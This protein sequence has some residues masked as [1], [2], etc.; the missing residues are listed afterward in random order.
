MLVCPSC[1][2]E[3]PERA[4]FCLAC[5]QS[6]AADARPT[7]ERKVVSVLFVDLVGFTDRSDR[8]DPEDVRATLRPY[9]ERVKA[10]IEAFG[11]TVEKFIG[12]AVMAV[13]GAPTAYEDD[14]ERAVR[15][16]LRI[17]ETMQ[18]LRGEGLD[19]AVR[20][21]VTTGEAVV[22]L[23][24]RPER[25][26]GIVAGDVVNTAARLQGA[27]PIG[28][29]IVD[30]ATMRSAERAIGFEPLESVAAKGK[31]D[32]IPVWR[33][34]TARS[35]F[36]VDTELRAE[37]L[38]VG[39]DSE[40]ALLSE[41]FARA[42]REPSTQLVT[43]VAEPGVGKSR[44]VW[45]FREEID[46]RPDLVR[47]RQGRCLPY[48]DGITFWALG[49][50]VKAEAGVLETDSPAEALV[51]LS[52]VVGVLEDE[53]DR[54]W[55][56]ERLAPLVGA[57]D[58]V[59][60][61]GR[62]EAFSAWQ[63]YLEALAVQ[64]P[65]VLVIEDL[66]WADAALLDFVE[67][68]LDWT[69]DVPLMVLATARPEL[70]DTRP[71]WSGGRR[72]SA[73]LGLSPLSDEDTARL[74]SSLLERSVLPAETQA[75]LLERAGGNPLYAEQYVRML[76]DAGVS[77]GG[78][79][80]ETVQALI[81]ARLDTLAPEL[82]SLLQDASVLGK[83]FWT[84]ALAAMGARERDDVLSG[85]R[86]LV[87]REFVRPARVSSMRD[88]EEF[89]FWHVLVRDVS[90]QQI[91]RA[92]RGQK[93]V[94]AAEWIEHASEGRLSD[95]AEFL[96]HHYAQALELGRA[97]GET[98]NH[99]EVEERLVRFSVLAGDRAMGLDIPAAE[100]AYRRALATVADAAQRANILVKLGDALQPQGLLVESEAAYEE[101]IPTLRAAGDNRGAGIAMVTLGRA[102]WRRGETL[103]AR[104]VSADAVALLE[105]DPGSDLV[106]AYGRMAAIDALGGRSEEA[107]AWA[108]KAIELASELRFENVTRAL[109]MRG[110]A[111]LD[112][113]DPGGM[114][115][116]RSAVELALEL[117]LPAEDTAIAMGN[118]GEQVGL[119]EGLARGR[120]QIEAG[121]EF[122]R[123]RGHTHHVVY[124][125]TS[126]L[127]HLF[128]EGRWD[129]LLR[130]AVELIE[131]DRDRGG[132]QLELWALSD[133][134]Q[135]LVHRGK[136]TSA[137]NA[138]SVA[139]PRAREVGDPQ[140][141]LPLL[142]SAAVTAYAQNDLQGAG[143][144]LDEYEASSGG[145]RMAV[146]REISVWLTIVALGVDGNDRVERLLS[147]EPWTAC[148]R[149]ALSHG[150]ALVAEAA[151]R[152][153]EAAQLFA[154][155]A[156]GWKAWGSIPMR[157]YALLG[158]GTSSGDATAL[159]ESEAIFASLGATPVTGL[160]R[161]TRQQ[162]V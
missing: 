36:G 94:E 7:E 1:G 139:L 105:A 129:E 35:R 81:A 75:A 34:T 4:R 117:N 21:A 144:L 88:E 121:L 59:A 90:Y 54:A 10:D 122:A 61:V 74:V 58:E 138:L 3:N 72:N 55:I 147:Y 38:F 135:V 68:L 82:K 152:P 120:D 161:P 20:A 153:G 113:G 134:A 66:H 71:G 106:L 33:A 5:G 42:L 62:D 109:G 101:A 84:G 146:D 12:D 14:A 83:V 56:T 160:A 154:E 132:T 136:A 145:I 78:D 104:E 8:A 159:A 96:A 6:L 118:L 133:Y 119:T 86:E 51:K 127:W 45:E 29:V 89:S 124:S 92:A 49:E 31:Q 114:E 97:A 13:F 140:T 52:H 108:N 95:H 125:R 141:V 102:L 65:T 99:V 137:T 131:W 48:G 77:S 44:L 24:A 43:V 70:Y 80:P 111:R 25:G 2:E 110:V 126:L 98:K 150:R 18:A 115:D 27:A 50:I 17:L 91:P 46:R 40:L 112:L 143:A 103:R 158:L 30:A 16:A 116:V 57:Q 28:A 53:S 107:V 32:P 41:T 26:E 128:H 157:A 151:G 23:G 156:D 155:A 87:R 162:Q 22:S 100:A 93:H 9:H 85:L 73:T 64:R 37:T 149:H 19:V 47:W 130:E 142:V 11:G 67:H 123:S 39:R 148:G 76:G 15:A 79:L 60:G 63:R 69:A